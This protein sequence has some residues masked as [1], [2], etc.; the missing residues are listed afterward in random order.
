MKTNQTPDTVS[1]KN[2]WAVLG[3]FATCVT[4]EVPILKCTIPGTKN[5][6]LQRVT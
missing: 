6:D 2:P 5:H 1:V 4:N 3:L